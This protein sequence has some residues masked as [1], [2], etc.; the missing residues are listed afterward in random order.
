MRNKLCDLK[1]NNLGGKVFAKISTSKLSTRLYK[2]IVYH[3][4]Q[5]K[6]IS[7]LMST[8]LNKWIFGDVFLGAY[9]TLFDAGEN[10]RVGFARAR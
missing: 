10:Q 7:M 4:L 6:C 2:W 9:Y 8:S 5:G 1:I 3:F